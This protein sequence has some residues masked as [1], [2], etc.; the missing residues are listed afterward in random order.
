[1][2]IKTRVTASKVSIF[3]QNIYL[4]RFLQIRGDIAWILWV[5]FQPIL[6][7]IA[8]QNDDTEA[9]RKWLLLFGWQVRCRYLWAMA[10]TISVR[11][12]PK[13]P[14]TI[15]VST[16]IHFNQTFDSNQEMLMSVRFVSVSE[17]TAEEPRWR[18]RT[19]RGPRQ[20]ISNNDKV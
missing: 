12:V 9:I 4:K 13:C 16:P 3:R 7:S 14:H 6:W 8:I 18:G 19:R 10:A 15:T 1:M 20:E 2:N 17:A 5:Y 11:A